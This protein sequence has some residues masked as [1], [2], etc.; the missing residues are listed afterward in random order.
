M[1]G[2]QDSNWGW[3]NS[4]GQQVREELLTTCS[5]VLTNICQWW[6]VMQTSAT[7]VNRPNGWSFNGITNGVIKNMKLWQVSVGTTPL[8]LLAAEYF[9][10]L[11][12]GLEF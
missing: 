8:L 10:H 6:D 7:Q 1:K 2:S 11:A 12:R 9:R 4:N 5:R 3:V